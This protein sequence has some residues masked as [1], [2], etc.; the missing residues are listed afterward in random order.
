MISVDLANQ[1]TFKLSSVVCVYGDGK[2]AFATL[3]D[4]TL[5][6]G[7]GQPRLGA[8]QALTS[9]FLHA[10]Q[11]QIGVRQPVEVLPPC[12]LA[13]TPEMIAWHVPAT[14]RTMFFQT[15]SALDDHTGKRFPQPGLVFR[16][17]DQTLS[18]RAL[19]T[20]ERPTAATKLYVAPYYNTY[21]N[22][23]V[24]LGSMRRPDHASA[25]VLD[26]WVDGFFGSAFSHPAGAVRLTTQKGGYAALVAKIAG[27]DAPFP[28][29]ALV[30]A[31]QT[32]GQFLTVTD[33]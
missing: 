11:E 2:D 9:A 23:S 6:H 31:E 33:H 24:C 21:D 29:G 4:V 8:A 30:D 26:A 22:G 15:G 17:V 13:R 16:L 14:H 18:V 1:H 32:L 25:D 10:L 28:T 7:G 19:A 27:S 3:H 12:V 20:T 5:P